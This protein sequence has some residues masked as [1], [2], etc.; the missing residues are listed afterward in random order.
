MIIGVYGG[1]HIG[2]AAILGGAILD[3]HH[4]CGLRRATVMSARPEHTRRLV[5]G[6]SVPVEIEVERYRVQAVERRL[7]DAQALVLGGGPLF[8][9]PRILARHLASAEAARRR[10]I[11]FLIERIGVLALEDKLC[12]WAARRVAMMASRISVRSEGS[13]RHRVM[14]GLNVEI[15]PDP[16]FDYLASRTDLDRLPAADAAAIDDLLAGT[17]GALTVGLNLRPTHDD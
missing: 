12:V 10:G 14:A 9:S 2:D 16:A 7:K 1:D 4:R 11:P 3:L 6:L 13:A 5:A 15:A 8:A 17:D